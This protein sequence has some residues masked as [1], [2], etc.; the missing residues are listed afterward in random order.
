MI[1]EW[2][3]YI[4]FK[5]IK[6]NSPLNVKRLSLEKIGN[7]TIDDECIYLNFN[8]RTCQ[9]KTNI[10]LMIK[11]FCMVFWLLVLI[12]SHCYHYIW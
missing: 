2:L 8:I 5:M 9:T 1:L 12:K 3:M 10:T 4:L 11:Y 6:P 7:D